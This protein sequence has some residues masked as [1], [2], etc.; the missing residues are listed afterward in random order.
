MM[1]YDFD[2]LI[3]RVGTNSVKWDMRK[4]KF[5]QED[6]IPLWVA[7]M[8]FPVAQQ[9]TEALRRR[10]EHPVYGYSRPAQS[11]IDTI[12]N[13]L[14]HKYG[15]TVRP[16]WLVFTPGVIPAVAA[17][18]RAYTH[19]GDSVV[20]G[21]PVYHPF[22]SV[23]PDAGCRIA[24]NSLKLEN[25][26]YKMD[27]QDLVRHF[28]SDRSLF[29]S[30]PPA[31]AML[32]CNPHN[33]V[34][35]VWSR[36]E[37]M[38]AGNI[39]IENG[40]V[41]ISDEVHCELL[42]DGVKHTP[43]A[44]ISDEFA[45]NSLVCMSASKTFNLAGLAA[46]V[47]IIPNPKLRLEFQRARGGIMPQPDIMAMT[48]LEAAFR[49]GDEWLGQ[50]LDYLQEN[51]DYLVSY[52][53]DRVPEIKVIKPEGTYLVWLDCRGLGLDKKQLR[54]FFIYEAGV[55]LDDGSAFGPGGEGFQR[56]NIACPK[57]T[58]AEALERIEKAVKELG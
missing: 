27:Y 23:L 54:E 22:W 18:L 17:A 2:R 36:Q 41:V 31:K 32:L 38:E 35:R 29:R 4:E 12:I 47:I 37:L 52:F 46:S 13:R 26:C 51:L 15:W 25:G 43:F 56:M 33:P 8:D 48:A 6:V 14:Q 7:D 57:A 42:F 53:K 58:L 9:I 49:D 20:M 5:G 28:T 19:P 16:E 1:K 21:A 45:Q 50:L 10:T 40:A 39:A 34:G 30:Q 44:S 24:V 11:L 55:G 3:P